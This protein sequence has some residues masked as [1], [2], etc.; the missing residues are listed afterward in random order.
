MGDRRSKDQDEIWAGSPR[1]R[2]A[3]LKRAIAVS[4]VLL[5]LGGGGFIAKRFLVTQRALPIVAQKLPPRTNDVRQS[6]LR[7]DLDEVAVLPEAYIT[8]ALASE[9]C[10]AVDVAV[11]LSSAHDKSV[12]DLKK[13]GVLDLTSSERVRTG[14]VCGEAIRKA[15]AAP[16]FVSVSFAENEAAFHVSIVRATM[17]ELPPTLGLIRHN[18][19]GLPGQCFKTPED[20][21]DCGDDARAAFHDGQTWVFGTVPA[22][23]AFARAYTSARNELTTTVDILRDTIANTDESDT[24]EITAKPDSI[25]WTLPCYLSAPVAHQ[26]EFVDACF[27]KGQDKLLESIVNKVRGLAIERDMLA[28]AAAYHFAFVL[29]ARDGDTA[30]DLEKDLQD[31]VRDWQAQLSNS[32]PDLTRLI[33]AKSNY[34]HDAFWT[35]EF[36]PYIRAMRAMSVSRN[37]SIVRLTIHDELRSEEAKALREFVD[38]RTQDQS[39]AINVIDAILQGTPVSEKSLAVFLAPEV[40]GWMVLPK[41]SA[42]DCAAFD[43]K[44]QSLSMGIPSELREVQLKMNQRF[45][46]TACVGGALLKTS[47]S[48]L[49]SAADLKSFAACKPPFDVFVQVAARKLE[50]Q[51]LAESVEPAVERLKMLLGSKIEFGSSGRV[52]FSMADKPPL[53]GDAEVE[54]DDGSGATFVFPTPGKPGRT[55][56][57]FVGDSTMRVTDG[58][59]KITYKRVTFDEALLKAAVDPEPANL[60]PAPPTAIEGVLKAMPNTVSPASAAHAFATPVGTALVVQVPAQ[61]QAQKEQKTDVAPVEPSAMSEEEGFLNVNSIPRNRSRLFRGANRGGRSIVYCVR[62]NFAVAAKS[63]F[64]WRGFSAQGT[65][66]ARSA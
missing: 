15:M 14:L 65:G 12:A 8:A 51:W 57:N 21:T 22:I 35:S 33:R 13:S 47:K 58:P 19:S 59:V 1:A 31:L 17:D 37:G 24:V 63:T 11:L 26:E 7:P 52:A 38:T 29:L 32:E 20:K 3:W 4:A 61:G 23:E 53:E 44:L 36:D 28:H 9:V 41:A 54:S 64:H 2:H 62:S 25:P 49:M 43:A 45:A 46:K 10:G 56:V 60:E 55:S 40:A 16:S 42:V 34:I 48:C 39:A 66:G 30:R 50:G 6:R 5:L 27:P 18:F